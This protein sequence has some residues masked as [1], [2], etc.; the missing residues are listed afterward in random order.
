M[1]TNDYCSARLFPRQRSFR[2]QAYSVSCLQSV[3]TLDRLVVGV[4]GLGSSGSGST[5]ASAVGVLLAVVQGAALVCLANIA[6]VKTESGWVDVS[7]APEEKGTKDGLR[8]NVKDT[9]EDGFG[10]RGNHISTLGQAPRD[11]VQEPQRDGPY[12]TDKVGL[13]HFGSQRFGVRPPFKDHRPGNEEE[14]R[15][16]KDEKSPFVAGSDQGTNQAGNNHYLIEEN[17][18]ENGRG[19]QTTGE[20]KVEK[21]QR[22]GE[23][24]VNVSHVED[25]SHSPANPRVAS[26][27]FHLDGRPSQ[28]GAHA[29]VGDSSN[30]SDSCSNVVKEPLSLRLPK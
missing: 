14:G 21:Q 30:E 20:E 19:W 4:S 12:T 23:D 13:R 27:E 8:E 26:F 11:W 17:S 10:V 25:L 1:L 5:V 6:N 7:V 3:P 29:E 9:I 16:S 18:I 15:S 24:P 22:S 2:D 28:I